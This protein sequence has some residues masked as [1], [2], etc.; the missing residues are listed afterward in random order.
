MCP[1]RTSIKGSR[2]AKAKERRWVVTVNVLLSD[3][4]TEGQR[5]DLDELLLAAAIRSDKVARVRVAVYEASPV[6]AIER[7]LRVCRQALVAV[8]ASFEGVDVFDA[9]PWD[10]AAA[11]VGPSR[12]EGRE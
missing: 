12:G 7:A 3:P 2:V 1:I 8:D 11:C 6:G 10:E 9:R 4:L 5:G